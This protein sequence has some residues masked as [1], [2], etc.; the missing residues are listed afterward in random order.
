VV[1]ASGDRIANS[2]SLSTILRDMNGNLF[3]LWTF[4]INTFAPRCVHHEDW[5]AVSKLTANSEPMRFWSFH[6][7]IFTKT[8]GLAMRRTAPAP[9]NRQAKPKADQRMNS[10][11]L[12]AR[13]RANSCDQK[14]RA[15][16]FTY[17]NM[18]TPDHNQVS[19]CA[20][21]LWRHI[22]FRQSGHQILKRN[23]A[24]Y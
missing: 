16:R 18:R 13:R 19:N 2:R 10:Q 24:K 3:R 7:G 21:I 5:S 1:W 20:I 12:L 8:D 4:C 11:G 14:A 15:S 23:D 9:R 22:S 6:W 17:E